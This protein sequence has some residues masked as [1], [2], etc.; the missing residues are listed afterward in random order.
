[1]RSRRLSQRPR[2]NRQFSPHSQAMTVQSR[3]EIQSETLVTPA[4]WS[5]RASIITV[6]VATNA[7]NER[8][9]SLCR[10]MP[11]SMAKALR[12]GNAA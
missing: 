10:A 1:M 11:K 7:I 9:R 2:R 6:N 5:A 8:R 12:P 4:G 3:L